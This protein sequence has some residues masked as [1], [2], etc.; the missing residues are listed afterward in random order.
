MQGGDNDQ[1]DRHKGNCHWSLLPLAQPPRAARSR[2]RYRNTTGSGGLR[3]PPFAHTS[4][5]VSVTSQDFVTIA[6]MQC[7]EVVLWQSQQVVVRHAPPSVHDQQL[8]P[9][10]Q[11]L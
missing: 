7:V 4:T 3:G 8:D 10:L 6:Q 2:W 9:S 11:S 5:G 1:R